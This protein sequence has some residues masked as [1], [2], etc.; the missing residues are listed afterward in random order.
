MSKERDFR[1]NLPNITILD[2][3]EKILRKISEEVQFPLPDEDKKNIENMITYL[4]M[5]QIDEYREKYD[6]RAGM[7]LSYV[8]IGVPKR[9][10][11]VVDEVELGEFQSYTIINPEIVSKSEE[12]IYV[13]E[14]EGCLS[15][16]RETE[17]IVPRNARMTINAYDIE[18]KP[19]TIRVREDL[20]VAF[21]HEIDHLNG[22]L[23]TDKIDPKN[24][25][26]DANKMRE[27]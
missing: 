8:Q 15:I 24:P 2:E 13:G 20:S 7:G 23:F 4:K 14:G 10:F 5:S 18:G 17:G 25:Y 9:I 6:L 12:L 19:F 21:Q 1:V 3:K 16:N 27:I 11:V 26:K 22:I